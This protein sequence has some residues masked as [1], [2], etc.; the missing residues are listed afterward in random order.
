MIE[1]LRELP[2][3]SEP[4]CKKYCQSN[5]FTKNSPFQKCPDVIIFFI[6]CLS[7]AVSRSSVNKLAY[8]SSI[9][10]I[11][12]INGYIDC[13]DGW[14]G[15][16]RQGFRQVSECV[17]IRRLQVPS[18][19]CRRVCGGDRRFRGCV[20]SGWPNPAVFARSRPSHSHPRHW[21]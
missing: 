19:F 2:A 7:L 18:W 3:L 8:N 12:K 11:D 5:Q 10:F 4:I 9:S 1:E 15:S 6:V 13:I 21:R 14:R 17:S 20:C 16:I